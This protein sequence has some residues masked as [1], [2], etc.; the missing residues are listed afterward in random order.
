MT[1]KD[2][3]RDQVFSTI[4][5]TKAGNPDFLIVLKDSKWK[6]SNVSSHFIESP[7]HCVCD[8]MGHCDFDFTL[9]RIE[10]LHVRK[11]FGHVVLI[12][13]IGRWVTWRCCKRYI[14]RHDFKK[15]ECYV[16]D[17]T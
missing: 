14:V 16:N 1:V 12:D 13:D 5:I 7:C 11:T 4:N 17:I 10:F 3:N 9:L 6:V 8:N 2:S 15:W